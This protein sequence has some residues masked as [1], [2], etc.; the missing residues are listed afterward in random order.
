VLSQ[1]LDGQYLD[2]AVA[3][4]A[5]SRISTPHA[6]NYILDQA[7]LT[8]MPPEWIAQLRFAAAQGNDAN[9]LKLIAQIPP[10]HSS[11]IKALTDLVEKYQFD[12]LITLIQSI[13]LGDL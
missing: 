6:P 13:D 4:E 2:E 1:H 12:R 9:G 5:N 3:I 7:A 8:V 11:L 10:E